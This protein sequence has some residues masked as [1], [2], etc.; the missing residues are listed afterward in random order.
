MSEMYT[1][2]IYK[3]K[4]WHLKLADKAIMPLAKLKNGQQVTLHKVEGEKEYSTYS[5]KPLDRSSTKKTQ[6]KAAKLAIV[7][8]LCA[9]LVIPIFLAIKFFH[10]EQ[11]RVAEKVAT[12]VPAAEAKPLI[13]LDQVLD[14]QV[15]PPPPSQPGSWLSGWGWGS[16]KT[17]RTTT[18][19]A[20][21]STK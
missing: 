3:E 20:S 10:P 19:L 1:S 7:I 21:T 13:R 12:L 17:E 16:P 14:E 4:P 8:L 15:P 11:K 2:Y 18:P 6:S 5:A 9:A